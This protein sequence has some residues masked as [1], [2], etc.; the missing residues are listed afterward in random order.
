LPLHRKP[1]LNGD[2][3]Y[4]QWLTTAS[5]SHPIERLLTTGIIAG[6]AADIA[7]TTTR[8]ASSRQ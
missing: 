1:V 5:R 7:G 8:R 2:R 3:R 6:I 4:S